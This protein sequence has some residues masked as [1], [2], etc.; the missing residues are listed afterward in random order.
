MMMMMMQHD[1]SIMMMHD[2]A[3]E[4]FDMTDAT[5]IMIM[6]KILQVQSSTSMTARQ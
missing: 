3:Y 1:D 2:D 5:D 6:S 4:M